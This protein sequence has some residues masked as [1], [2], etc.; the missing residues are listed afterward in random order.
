M[1]RIGIL[2]HKTDYNFTTDYNYKSTADY[3]PVLL[4]DWN[5]TSWTNGKGIFEMKA[6]PRISEREPMVHNIT[7]NYF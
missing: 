6:G 5:V 2:D 3:A 7:N 1:G 4:E